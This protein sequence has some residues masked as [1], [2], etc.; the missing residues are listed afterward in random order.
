MVGGF[1]RLPPRRG[2]RRALTASGLHIVPE[3]IVAGALTALFA[4]EL[5]LEQA[6]TPCVA[7]LER[8]GFDDKRAGTKFSI[9][10]A[11]KLGALVV[12][13][14]GPARGRS[15]ARFKR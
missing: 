11:K 5:E 6:V 8:P 7:W 10:V 12:A 14:S 1:Q 15:S 13:H 9:E 2:A 4:N 3:D